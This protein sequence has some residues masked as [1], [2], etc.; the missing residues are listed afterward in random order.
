MRRFGRLFKEGSWIVCGQLASVVGS[1]L[2]VRVLTEYLDTVQ[3]G[4]LALGL[5]V[6]GLVNQV[7]MGGITN[8]ITRYYSIANEKNDLINYV[9]ASIRIMGYATVTIVAIA[10]VLVIGLISL[11]YFEWLS[12]AFAALVFSVISGYNSAL[13]G[14]QNAAR[15]RSVVAFHGGL[16]AWLKILFAM[17]MVAWIGASSTNVVIG[18]AFS[19]LLITCSQFI[20]LRRLIVPYRN[21]HAS[22]N[23]LSQIWAYSSPFCAWGFFTW[24]HLA[25]DKWALQIYATTQEVGL[26]AVLYQLG[27]TPIVLLTGV[28][29]SFLGPILFQKI[30]NATDETRKSLVHSITWYI[31]LVGL[32]M[33]G[34][35]FVLTFV[36]HKSIFQLLVAQNFHNISYLLPWMIS[37]GGLFAVGQILSLKLM[38]EM[39]TVSM[40]K[41]KFS[42]AIIGT[43]LNLYFA[44][45]FGICGVVISINLFSF[46][47][48]MWLIILTKNNCY[49]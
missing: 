1:L 36:F 9:R 20:F 2:L 13:N 15:Q 45:S 24:V 39:Q 28:F 32:V 25:S 47:Y 7:V 46:L 6:A 42:T 44:S 18:Y 8:G 19:S 3:Y 34:F 5:T 17:G 22:I 41:V 11:D 49:D 43:S 30:G 37:A 38:S 16:D 21:D 29:C 48:L 40:F 26:Y 31:A 35:G 10:F 23:W 33:T 14:I 27:Y 12:L 4:Q